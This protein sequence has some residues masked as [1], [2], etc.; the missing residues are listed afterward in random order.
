MTPRHDRDAGGPAALLAAKAALRE[1]VW[2][3]MAVKGINRFPGPDN[4]IPNFVG[5]ERAAQLLGETEE[6]QAAR[7]V[8]TSSNS[9]LA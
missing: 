6:W 4:R 8:R 9:S 7:T 3:A 5:A 2:A 1:R